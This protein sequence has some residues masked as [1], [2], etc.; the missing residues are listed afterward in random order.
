M[1]P[2]AAAA[3]AERSQQGWWGGV[4]HVLLHGRIGHAI[5]EHVCNL[6][7]TLPIQGGV[8]IPAYSAL[9]QEVDSQGSRGHY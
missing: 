4:L 8:T 5:P 2:P 6:A 7:Q 9:L 1:L 3:A